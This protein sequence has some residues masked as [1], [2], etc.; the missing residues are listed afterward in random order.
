MG[1]TTIPTAWKD[2]TGTSVLQDFEAHVMTSNAANTPCI[3]GLDFM[4]SKDS[5]L[6]LRDGQE[7][8]CLPGERGYSIQWS[9]GTRLLPLKKADSGHLM[10]QSDHF[11]TVPVSSQS[12][13]AGS[14]GPDDCVGES[15]A[16]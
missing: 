16:H 13:P 12:E 10:L 7:M 11:D 4:Q 3:M 9:E 5:V 6:I 8:L 2:D 15:P 1:M 14:T